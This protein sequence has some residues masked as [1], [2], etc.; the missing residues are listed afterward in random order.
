M[1]KEIEGYLL[2]SKLKNFGNFYKDLRKKY[3][4]K[5]IPSFN[6]SHKTNYF[7]LNKNKNNPNNNPLTSRSISLYYKN[8]NCKACKINLN[9]KAKLKQKLNKLYKAPKMLRNSSLNMISI[10]NRTNTQSLETERINSVQN[11][12]LN[13][14]TDYETD[15]FSENENTSFCQLQY[16]ENEIFKGKSFYDQLIKDKINYLKNN[17]AYTKDYKYEKHFKY[18]KYKKEVNLIFDSLQISFKD[19]SPNGD[20]FDNNLKIYLPFDLLPIFYYKG[21]EPFI[22][23]L[24]IAIKIEDNFE[25]IKFQEEKICEA[26]NSIRDFNKMDLNPDDSDE[27]INFEK[28]LRDSTKNIKIEKSIKHLKPT[29]LQKNNYFLK[30]NNFIFFWTSNIRTFIVTITLPC[31]HLNILENKIVINHFIDY[32]LLFYL[33][34]KKFS[35]WEYYIIKYFSSYSKFRNIFQQ[36]DSDSKL[37]NKNIFLKEPK[38]KINSFSDEHL[39]NIYT[40]QFNRNQSLI[41][42]SFYV[43]SVFIDLNHLQEKIYHIHFNFYHYLKLYQIAKYSNK[44]FFLIKFLEINKEFN[45]L[46]FNFE[47][48]DQFNIM[49]WMSNIRKFSHKSLINNFDYNKEEELYTEFDIFPKKIKVELKR[50]RWSIIKIVDKEEVQKTCEIENELEKYLI[51]SI[52][53][54]G[55]ESWTKLLNECLK[56]LNEPVPNLPIIHKKKYNKKYSKKYYLTPLEINKGY[57]KRFS[58]IIK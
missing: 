37:Y 32:E 47:K 50:P 15:F 7:L 18:G 35:N 43:N 56:R 42:K 21:V 22:K 49:S 14:I 9:F 39:M 51:D 53:N 19:L 25:N 33:Y 11:Q 45:T 8:A 28:M 46:K 57:M 12:I 40:D 23:F 38:S 4:N 26:L 20:F 52:N 17:K 34:A 2:K 29:I 10:S 30:Y 41:F 48:F 31:I 1:K 3:I 36:L 16:N 54:S 44:I 13:F 5:E 24:S 27:D 55:S 58:K 6:K